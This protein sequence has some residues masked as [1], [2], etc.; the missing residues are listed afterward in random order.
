MSRFDTL[1]IRGNAK[2]SAQS[3]TGWYG[4][5]WSKMACANTGQS[6][7]TA[8]HEIRRRGCAPGYSRREYHKPQ[9]RSTSCWL[10][11]SICLS[12][13]S[14]YEVCF[15]KAIVFMK[16]LQGA[17][18]SR[19]QTPKFR[20]AQHIHGV[21]RHFETLQESQMSAASSP[22]HKMCPSTHQT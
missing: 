18:T 20:R 1:S 11:M 15:L 5:A 2:L 7:P 22:G 17:H 8:L 6:S 14:S 9:K 12:L 13:R 3:K 4:L 10:F 16:S 19:Y 21:Y